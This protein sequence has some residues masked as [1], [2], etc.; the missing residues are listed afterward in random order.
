MGSSSGCVPLKEK[1]V[2][3]TEL[4]ET[5][6]Q[7]FY[8]ECHMKSSWVVTLALA[9]GLLIGLPMG[10]F[11]FQPSVQPSDTGL[12]KQLVELYDQVVNLQSQVVGLQSENISLHRENAQLQTKNSNLQAENTNLQDKI[13]LLET[14]RI[15]TRLGVRDCNWDSSSMRL[16]IAGEDWNAGAG[17]ANNCSL[18][19][20]LYQ[21]KS[22]AVD[23]RIDLGTLDSGSE[24]DI[25]ENIHYRGAALSNWSI[26]PEFSP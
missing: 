15:V 18:H 24:T 11:L 7:E 21:G 23:T 10:H 3:Q 1:F 16:Y 20:V 25:A 9:F 2:P 8:G 14:P 13:N 6:M 12:Q 4:I 22:V 17:P 26:V 5:W 19:V